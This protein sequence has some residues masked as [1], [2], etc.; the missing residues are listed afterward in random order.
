VQV[1]TKNIAVAAIVTALV[2]VLWYRVGYSSMAS[3]ASKANQAAQDA[4][5]KVKTMDA[6]VHALTPTKKEAAAQK[7]SAE[8][9]A[10][11]ITKTP[12]L[13]SFLRQTDAIRSASGVQFQSIT[14]SPPAAADGVTTINVSIS[15]QGTYRALHEYVDRLMALPRLVQIDNVGY[16]PGSSTSSSGQSSSGSS[17][18]SG[19]PT[20]EIFA[21][22][23]S[24]PTLQ[25]TL[26]GRVFT[27]AM[28]AIA[29]APSAASRPVS[30]PTK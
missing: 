6:S 5:A 26:T 15:L 4:E 27:Q 9:L 14:P 18:P 28:P 8:A 20:G 22:Q 16:A 10:A 17:G 7:A 13:A 11:A 23:G 24:A 12:A 2:L 1:K 29:S 25:L 21:G 3:Q 30:S 19:G